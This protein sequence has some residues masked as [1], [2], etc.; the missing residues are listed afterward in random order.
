MYRLSSY[1][2][3]PLVLVL[4][5]AAVATPPPPPPKPEVIRSSWNAGCTFNNTG[6]GARLAYPFCNNSLPLGERLSDLLGRMTLAE[7]ASNLHDGVPRLGVPPFS[8]SEDTHGVGCGCAPPTPA[9]NGTGCPTTFPNGPSLG[10]SFDRKLW[11][12]IGQ[13]IGIEARGLAN[14][15]KCTLYFLDP[16]LNL[17]RDAR[18][19]RAQEVPGEDPYLTG[20]YGTYIIKA[21]QQ[22]GLDPRYLA[23]ASTMKH[24]SIYNFEGIAPWGIKQYPRNA[25]NNY[26]TPTTGGCDGDTQ[27]PTDGH[28]WRQCSR[29]TMDAYPPA[30]DFS[31][32]YMKAFE[33]VAQRAK[34]AAIMCS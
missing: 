17:L 22:P 3:S 5:A 34:P 8:A 26:A 14:Q 2:A 19:G 1:V 29:M 12:R 21:T 18:W 32:Y 11:T 20:E 16:N 27:S 31:G 7:K 10:A 24:F 28:Q 15:G 23:A 4:V 13:T 6:K 33:I 30:R 9:T 25:T